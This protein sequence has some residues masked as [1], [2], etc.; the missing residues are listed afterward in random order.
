M[1]LQ[2]ESKMNKL[3]IVLGILVLVAIGAF[4]LGGLYKFEKIDRTIPSGSSESEESSVEA[5]TEVAKPIAEPETTP[6]PESIIPEPVVEPTPIVVEESVDESA[7]E[8]CIDDALIEAESCLLGSGDATA[9]K[10]E[11]ETALE[12][13]E[14]L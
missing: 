11:S 1:L 3:L 6:T 2:P 12:A 8:K 13:C 10:A 5:K 7:R 14:S 9:C 4:I